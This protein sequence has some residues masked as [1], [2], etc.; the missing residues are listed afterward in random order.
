MSKDRYRGAELSAVEYEFIFKREN[1]G[2]VKY[3][4]I[5]VDGKMTKSVVLNP[6]PFLESPKREFFIPYDGKSFPPEEEPVKLNVI[7]EKDYKIAEKKGENPEIYKA[8]LKVYDSWEAVNIREI[9]EKK[10]YDIYGIII[11]KEPGLLLEDDIFLA[12]QAPL[13][14]DP[15]YVKMLASALTIFAHSSPPWWG[16]QGGILEGAIGNGKQFSALNYTLD[17]IPPDFRRRSSKYYYNLTKKQDEA[18]PRTAIE[19]NLCYYN[20]ERPVHLPLPLKGH[21]EV[22]FLPRKEYEWRFEDTK[23]LIRASIIDSLLIKPTI[24][25]E[26]A[27]KKA[28][29]TVIDLARDKGLPCPLEYSG[30][31]PRISSG[32]ARGNRKFE[33][34]KKIITNALSLYEN[35]YEEGIKLQKDALSIEEISRMSNTELRVYRTMRDLGADEKPVS[36]EE[37]VKTTRLDAMKLLVALEGLQHKGVIYEPKRGHYLILPFEEDTFK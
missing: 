29:E 7:L 19:A 17:L 30:V 13:R 14:G 1:T 35:L 3:K 36:F 10:S 33:L 23:P 32:L 37:L 21:D 34:D 18:P 24:Q 25:S 27:L 31:I 12:F 22:T 26:K 4:N 8:K 20:P 11:E 2:F 5:E 9:L 15:T 6:S 16:A 28:E